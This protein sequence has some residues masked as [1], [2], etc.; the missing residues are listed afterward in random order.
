MDHF[1]FKKRNS[2]RTKG[3]RARERVQY[4]DTRESEVSKLET[5]NN[6]QLYIWNFAEGC[7]IE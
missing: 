6:S 5:L 2:N 3:E 4:F 1:S 7:A